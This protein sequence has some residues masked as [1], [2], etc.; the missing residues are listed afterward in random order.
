MTG[1]LGD[2]ISA[3]VSQ[4]TSDLRKEFQLT[5]AVLGP[6]IQDSQSVGSRKRRQIR[7][8]LENDGHEVFFPE[9]Y[10]A[11]VTG[12]LLVREERK[13]LGDDAVGLVILLYTDKSPGALVELT[14]F[15][16]DP[17]I[18]E[19]TAILFPAELFDRQ[20][21]VGNTVDYYRIKTLYT[22]RQ[23]EI[24]ELVEECRK[25]ASDRIQDES[26]FNN[27]PLSWG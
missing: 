9:D 20:S 6:G 1:S 23:F 19:K 11:P 27:P 25:V 10:C 2:Q 17:G 12:E 8:A 13:L 4:F 7:V 24:C 15:V 3:K 21:M 5:V 18:R 14:G 16:E 22:A 26:T